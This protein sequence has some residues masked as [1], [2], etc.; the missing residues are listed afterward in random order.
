MGN[1]NNNLDNYE[2][3]KERKLRLIKDYPNSVIMPIFL[4]DTSFA[5][6][7]ALIGA[8]I[9]TDKKVFEELSAESLNTISE[10]S[11]AATP[12]NAGIIMTNIAI[13]SKASSSGYSLSIA[14]GKGADK[15]S[16]VENAEESAVGRALDNL[17]YHSNAPSREEMEKVAYTEDALNSRQAAVMELD[18]LMSQLINKGYDPAYIQQQCSQIAGRQIN[19]FSD[20]SNDQMAHVKNIFLNYLQQNAG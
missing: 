20:L 16:W 17:G 11:K 6:N 15:A 7:Y 12:Q 4:S 9:W 13:A 18:N 3:V 5:F 19:N 2:R 8:L 1:W 14:G 10:L